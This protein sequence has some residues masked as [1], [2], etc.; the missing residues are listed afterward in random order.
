M[1]HLQ[2]RIKI[3]KENGLIDNDYSEDNIDSKLYI[4]SDVKKSEK[5]LKEVNAIGKMSRK[6]LTNSLLDIKWY[7]RYLNN[8]DLI[9][10]GTTR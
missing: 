4:D 1:T 6:N 10:V 7:L 8:V 5:K 2:S 3:L 9:L